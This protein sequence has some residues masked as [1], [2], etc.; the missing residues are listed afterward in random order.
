MHNSVAINPEGDS[1]VPLLTINY[2]DK[3]GERGRIAKCQ[4]RREDRAHRAVVK[5]TQNPV[6]VLYGFP[7]NAIKS[8]A[9]NEVGLSD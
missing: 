1:Q 7:L 5:N 4:W 3:Q 8:T 9:Q 6:N 2:V